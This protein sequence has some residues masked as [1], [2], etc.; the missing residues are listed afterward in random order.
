MS[1]D[2]FLFWALIAG[3]VLFFTLLVLGSDNH[4]SVTDERGCL[5][6]S[7]SDNRIIGEDTYSVQTYCPVEG[8]ND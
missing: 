4:A 2:A 3:I 1:R 7:H 5:I 6:K 8:K